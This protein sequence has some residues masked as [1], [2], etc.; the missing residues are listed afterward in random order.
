[1]PGGRRAVRAD[2][3]VV[4][5][6]QRRARMRTEEAAWAS[7]PYNYGPRCRAEHRDRIA[8]D[9]AR[10]LE[11]TFNAQAYRAHLFAATLHNC[12]GRLDRDPR[13]DARRPRR[14]TTA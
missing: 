8:D 14:R 3:E 5:F 4:A 11:H 7:V 6:F 13:A 9:I 10:R 2:D 12:Y 1:M